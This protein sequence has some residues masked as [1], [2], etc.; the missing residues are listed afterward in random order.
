MFKEV[1]CSSE[2]G[3]RTADVAASFATEVVHTLEPS[4]VPVACELIN[5]ADCCRTLVFRQTVPTDTNSGLRSTDEWSVN[6]TD[7]AADQY[8]ILDRLHTLPKS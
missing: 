2:A 8:S 3:S 6:P 5:E 7:S 1:S 4:D